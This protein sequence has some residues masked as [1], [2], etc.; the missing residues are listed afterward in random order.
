MG[1][2][3]GDGAVSVRVEDCAFL[4]G[5]MQ[6]EMGESAAAVRT[7]GGEDQGECNDGQDSN[8]AR[9]LGRAL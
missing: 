5:A 3:G 8:N 1:L 9:G 7:G 6:V 4:A 2:V